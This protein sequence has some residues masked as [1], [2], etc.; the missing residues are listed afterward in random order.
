MKKKKNVF[1]MGFLGKFALI[2][3][4]FVGGGSFAW[5]QESKSL[6]YTYGFENNNLTNEGWTLINTNTGTYTTGIAYSSYTSHA[7]TY[8]FRFY[9]NENPPQ[10]LISPKLSDSSTGL[11]VSF[12][13]RNAYASN[14][15][16]FSIGYTTGESNSVD[17]FTWKDEVVC[18]STTYAQCE[19]ELPAHTTYFAI[20]STTATAS[21]NMGNNYYLCIDDITVDINNPYKTP[22]SFALNSY[23][24]TSATFSWAAGNNETTWQFDYSTDPNFTPGNGINGTSV[25]ITSNPYTLSG[26]TT[27]TTYYASIRADYGSGNYSEWTDKVSFTPRNE[28]EITINNSSSGTQTVYFGPI[29]GEKVSNLIKSQIII[30]ANNLTSIQNRQITKLT[31]YST[32]SSISWGNATFE[33]YIKNTSTSSFPTSGYALEAWGTKVYNEASLSVVDGK[34]VVVFDTPFNYTSGNLLIGFK[35][36]AK[37][38]NNSLSW[39]ASDYI[40]GIGLYYYGSSS[41]RIS[42]SPKVT[43]TSTAITTDPVQMGPNGFTTFASP[44][45]LDLSNLPSGLTAYKAEVDAANSKVRFTEI[46]QAVPANT[47]MLLA[48]TAGETYNIPVADNGTAVENNDFFVNSTGG[49]FAAESGYTY[50]GLLKDSDP[51]TFGIFDPAS[52]AI[53]TNKAYLKVSS[54]VNSRLMCVFN[55]ATAI[56]EATT[57][58]ADA[59]V[60]DLQGRRVAQ[61]TKGLYIVNGKKVII[62]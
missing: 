39:L 54:S 25:S 38:T 8:Y 35:Q 53:P 18:S 17:G 16:A 26:L 37:G 40:G 5:A 7:G 10:Y 34:M 43:I 4:L 50:Y 44:R 15:E 19:Y 13:Y 57:A 42:Y 61:P 32:S 21:S 58:A 59:T 60:F 48:G 31:Y 55:D 2:V 1:S 12:Y 46:N 52:V 56:S 47:G 49:T 41:G 36:I 27:G 6:P 29:Y 33:V 51:L 28:T 9:S 3:A 11:V 20:K 14:S 30:P 62:K 23:G 22:T 24:V 45:A